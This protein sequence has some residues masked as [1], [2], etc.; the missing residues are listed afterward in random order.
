MSGE[1]RCPSC[2]SAL[3]VSEE[4]QGREVKCPRCATVFTPAE[5]APAAPVASPRE[6]SPAIRPAADRRRED[7]PEERPR[8]YR[9]RDLEEDEDYDRWNVSRRHGRA[10]A[11]SRVH[12]PGT[13]LQVW[14]AL[15]CLGA[16]ALLFLFIYGMTQL[17]GPVQVQ[18]SPG[19]RKDAIAATAFGGIGGAISAGLGVLICWGGTR[20]KALRS[21]G[22]AMAATILTSLVGGSTCIFLLALG[23]WPLIVLCDSAVREQF[24]QHLE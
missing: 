7:E 15:C 23:I 20:M 21:Y 9:R 16:C 3:R 14:G 4:L 24:D 1:I 12:G 13:L 2:S 6:D 11:L 18:L 10:Y 17:T 19:E 5:D 22:L 8:R